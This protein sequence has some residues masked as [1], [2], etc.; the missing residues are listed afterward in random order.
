MHAYLLQ[1]HEMI[2]VALVFFPLLFSVGMLI[3]FRAPPTSQAKRLDLID[4]LCMRS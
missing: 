4:I 3:L 2:F 1:H